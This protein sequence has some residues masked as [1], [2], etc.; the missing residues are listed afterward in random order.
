[1]PRRRGRVDRFD[2]PA[3][4]QEAWCH[5]TRKAELPSVAGGVAGH[6]AFDLVP[7]AADLV[8]DLVPGVAAA[9]RRPVATQVVLGVVEAAALVAAA[10]AANELVAFIRAH[11]GIRGV[12]HA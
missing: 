7:G 12:R 8:A 3:P 10:G 11:A 1:C 5:F 2:R 9:A 4:S 6:G